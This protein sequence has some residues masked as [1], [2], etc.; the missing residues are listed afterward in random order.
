MYPLYKVKNLLLSL[1]MI[2]ERSLPSLFLWANFLLYDFNYWSGAVTTV[3]LRDS[4]YAQKIEL[5]V[6]A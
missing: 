4:K 6:L 1:T 5:L 3:I 2:G